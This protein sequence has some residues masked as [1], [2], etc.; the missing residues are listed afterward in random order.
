MNMVKKNATRAVGYARRSTDLQERSIP[1]QKAYVEKWAAENGYEVVRWYVDD[2][3]SGTSA[4]GR[5]SFERMI[6]AAENGRDFDAVLCYDISRFSRG[7]T[8]ETGFYLHRLTQVGVQAIFCAEGIPEGDEG[9]LLQGVKSWQARQYSVKLS[10][11]TIRGSISNIMERRSAPGGIP[12]FGYDKQHQTASGQV[13]R[14]FRWLPDGSKQEF[15]PEGKL[16]RILGTDETVKKAKSDIVRYVPSTPERVAVVH[17][18]FRQCREGYGYRYVAARLNE[19]GVASHDGGQW[20]ASQIKRIIENPAYRGALAWNRRT[21]GKL[22]GVDGEG[23]LR[24]KRGGGGDHSNPKDD[25]YVVEGVHEPLV[26]PEEF[27]Q[28]Q[29]AVVK[30]RW[31][32]GQARPTNRSLLSGLIICRHCGHHFLQ[33]TVNSMSGGVAKRYRYYTDGGYN[34]GGRATCALTNIPADALDAFVVGKVRDVLIG[35]G[36]GIEDAVE[37][38]VRQAMGGRPKNTDAKVQREIDAVTRRI[39]ATVAM[40]ADPTFDGLDELRTTLADLKARRDTLQARLAARTAS[41]TP[42][43]EADVR[44]WASERLGRLDTLLNRK[45]SCLEARKLVHACVERIEIFPDEQRGVLYLPP[46]AYACF[47]RELSTRVA[48]GDYRGAL[49]MKGEA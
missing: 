28:A 20:N 32:G 24:P 13:L 48:H 40:L 18:I 45:A 2:A 49:K 17:R 30:R 15:S 47:T 38:F 3:I 39:K 4:K 11:D 46:D 5:Q 41:A 26:T 8:N 27:E 12:P 42:F 16:V 9:E 7:G 29:R 21:I 19:E 35:D 14:T 43:K 1:D 34:R 22:H 31:A 23:R 33:K 10:R 25:W 6:K 44:Q 37:A 36:E